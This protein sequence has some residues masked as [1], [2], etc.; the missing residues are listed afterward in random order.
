MNKY[1]NHEV[2]L[3]YRLALDINLQGEHA[4]QI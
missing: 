1:I 2:K 3:E 4:T